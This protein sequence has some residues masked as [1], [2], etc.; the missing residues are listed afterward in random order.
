MTATNSCI[1]GLNILQGNGNIGDD[2]M[3]CLPE[4]PDGQVGTLDDNLRLLDGSPCI[5]TGDDVQVPPDVVDIDGDGDLTEKLPWD[6]DNEKPL[7][8]HGRFFNVVSGPASS[9]DMGAYENQHI[10]VCPS[11]IASAGGGPPP[12]GVVGI[13]DQLKMFSDWGSC[14]GCGADF[15]CD[16]VINGIDYIE[17]IANWGPCPSQSSSHHYLEA[18]EEALELMGFDDREEYQEWIEGASDAEV[19]A[20]GQLL[21]VLLLAMEEEDED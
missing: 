18:L 6:R 3:F 11:D 5:D 15:N 1:Q 20:S 16:L 12:D 13:N 17:L 9:V 2:P 19:F 21:A 7:T 10:S 8:Q 4:G 14:P